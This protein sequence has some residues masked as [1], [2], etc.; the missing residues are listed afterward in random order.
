MKK[1][2]GALIPTQLHNKQSLT[3]AYQDVKLMKNYLKTI[4]AAPIIKSKNN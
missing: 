4:K 3:K 2:I 1:L